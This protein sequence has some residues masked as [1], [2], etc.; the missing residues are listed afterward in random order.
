MARH[1]GAANGDAAVLLHDDRR[2]ATAK[3]HALVTRYGY[4]LSVAY[5][6]GGAGRLARRLD[7]PADDEWSVRIALLEK[8]RHL[9]ADHGRCQLGQATRR[10]RCF[11][12]ISRKY[13]QWR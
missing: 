11:L 2:L 10:D 9:G 4:A 1:I 8:Q 6:L 12:R 7:N 5:H 13:D 3:L